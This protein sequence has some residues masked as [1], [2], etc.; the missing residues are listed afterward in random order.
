MDVWHHFGL[1]HDDR[2][3]IEIDKPVCKLCFS[4][5]S[6]KDGN[7]SNLYAHLKNKHPEEYT[8]TKMK[9]SKPKKSNIRNPDQPTIRDSFLQRQKLST[10]G[11]QHKRLTRSITYWLAKDRQPEYSVEKPGF[12]QMVKTFCPRYQLPSRSYFSRTALPKLYSNTYQ[13]IQNTLAS[14]EVSY[15]SAT[16]DL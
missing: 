13:Q 6:A 14:H 3:P 9:A 8:A 5:V 10:S 1:R 2:R 4:N 11:N 15:F 16:T 12:V 7:T